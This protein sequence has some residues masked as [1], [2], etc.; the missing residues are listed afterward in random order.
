MIEA[1]WSLVPISSHSLT[2]Q[3]DFVLIFFNYLAQTEICDF[4]LAVVKNDVLRF[5]IIVDNLLLL[6]V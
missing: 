3:F 6:I 5:K 1:F 2:R 4:D